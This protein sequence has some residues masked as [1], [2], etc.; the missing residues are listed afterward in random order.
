MKKTIVVLL[1]LSI[2]ACQPAG[3][4][5][6]TPAS[7]VDVASKDFL[8]SQNSY[9]HLITSIMQRQQGNEQIAD[10]LLELAIKKDEDS[11]Y[12]WSQKALSKAKQLKWQEAFHDVEQSLQND[13]H[14]TESLI[15][16]GKLLT[17][18]KKSE[19]AIEYYQKAIDVNN[20]HEEAYVVL[21]REYLTLE[22]KQRAIQTL[23]QC[24]QV[25]AESMNCM[26]YLATI[27][28]SDGQYN[29][30]IQYFQVIHS[31]NPDNI[32]ILQSLGDLYLKLKQYDKALTAFEKLKLYSSTD[33]NGQIKLA[34]LYY[35]LNQVDKATQEFLSIR[36]KF[37]KSDKLNYFLGLLYLQ[38]KNY[39]Q[40]FFYLDQV[41]ADSKHF[42]DAVTK[43][44]A[45]LR[46]QNRFDEAFQLIEKKF[47]KKETTI[48][49]YDLKISLLL[50]QN[51]EKKAL[52]LVD[53]ALK[54]FKNDK[55]LLFRKGL[56]HNK[57]NE[58]DAAE[59]IFEHILVLFP[60]DTKT[61]NYLGYSYLEKNKNTERAGE[62]LQRAYNLNPQDPF[63]TDSLGWYYFK[64][65]QIQKS[66]ELLLKAKKMLP[67]ETTILQHLG[68]VYLYLN[69][70]K[71]AQQFFR[72]AL[73]ILN[74]KTALN[75]DDQR[76]LE[77]LQKKLGEF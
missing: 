32:K 22:Q 34:L 26:Y 33:L 39:D 75:A 4:K 3:K 38:N 27:L 10:N 46:Q 47:Q 55:T 66:L 57:L 41:K 24:L 74:A 70:K 28:Q 48:F 52:V 44:V 77:D 5:L 15:L 11:G 42:E 49:V 14:N 59:K 13:P 21:A 9:Y 56:I 19:K 17:S 65:G 54:T 12:L 76:Q 37:P 29:Q 51:N 53:E 62:L 69:N 36:E 73:Q 67:R 8:K 43:Q 72:E 58:W 6:Q 68:E 2:I 35:E 18:Q 63:I 1:V 45:L 64:S 30:A 40:A 31:L 16:M 20:T 60:N 23:K 7:K 25:Q 50:L 71:L 61:L